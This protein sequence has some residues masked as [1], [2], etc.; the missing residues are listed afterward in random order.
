MRTLP[1]NVALFVVLL[2]AAG[3]VA[4]ESVA[5]ESPYRRLDSLILLHECAVAEKCL[6]ID[7]LRATAGHHTVA[8]KV[9]R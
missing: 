2:M 5:A 6:R 4:H 3:V 7:S 9:V 8:T 1:T